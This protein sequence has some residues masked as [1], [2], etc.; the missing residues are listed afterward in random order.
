[1]GGWTPLSCAQESP[2]GRVARGLGPKSDEVQRSTTE[3]VSGRPLTQGL[4]GPKVG[5]RSRHRAGS[6]P[7]HAV[8]KVAVVYH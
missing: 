6:P 2:R 3:T 1:M 5:P 4:A 8:A 7:V